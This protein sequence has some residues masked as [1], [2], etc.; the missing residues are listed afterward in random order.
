MKSAGSD[1]HDHNQT[2][3]TFSGKLHHQFYSQGM[4]FLGSQPGLFLTSLR[5]TSSVQ[6]PCPAPVS[7]NVSFVSGYLG[8]PPDRKDRESFNF[9][10]FVAV[11]EAEKQTQY[12]QKI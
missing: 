7:L 2:S 5:L 10:L 6:S 8:F 3:V 12:C 11:K 1:Q 9:S 4:K